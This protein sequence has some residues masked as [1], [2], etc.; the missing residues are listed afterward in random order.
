[1]NQYVNLKNN[2]SSAKD[3]VEAIENFYNIIF[4]NYENKDEMERLREDYL[5]IHYKDCL[6]K[7]CKLCAL[8]NSLSFT[9]SNQK[10]RIKEEWYNYIKEAYIYHINQ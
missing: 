6:K 3:A 9:G 8:A 1:M 4:S 10:E 2:F 7:S 5:F